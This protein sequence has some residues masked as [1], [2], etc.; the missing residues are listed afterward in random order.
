MTQH[1][2][3]PHARPGWGNFYSCRV[4]SLSAI[5][6]AFFLL[7]AAAAQKSISFPTEDGVWFFADLYGAGEKGV[8]L[9]AE[10]PLTKDP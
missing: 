4:R 7:N 9:A 5:F 3:A 8:V 10:A 6:A 2:V 1:D